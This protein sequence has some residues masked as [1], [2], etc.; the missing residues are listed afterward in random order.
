MPSVQRLDDFGSWHHVMNRGL[1]KRPVFETPR[2]VQFFLSRIAHVVRL[3]WLEVHAFTILTTHFHLLVRSPGNSL[4]KAMRR[5]ELDFVR[6]FNVTRDRDG[7]LFR[8]RFVSRRIDTEA[9]WRAVLAYIDQNAV[10]ARMVKRPID[11]PWCSA[12]YYA[13]RA[14]PQWMSREVVESEV[15]ATTRSGRFAPARYAEY[16]C[17]SKFE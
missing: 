3:G 15:A 1:A 2:D 16:V 6:W 17:C 14:G 13:Q 5:I 9:Y 10:A 7:S 11:H 12:H 8:G 4:S